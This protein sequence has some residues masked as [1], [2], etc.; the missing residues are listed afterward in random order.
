MT[1]SHLRGGKSVPNIRIPISA[2]SMVNK[3]AKNYC[4][5]LLKYRPRSEQELCE[6]LRRKKFEEAVIQ[7]TV[8]F[9]KAKGFINDSLFAKSWIESR[10]RKPLGFR[11]IAQELRLKGIDESL[12]ESLINKAGSDYSEFDVVR[13]VCQN[14]F[15]RLIGG[16]NLPTYEVGRLKRRLY[17]YLLR[18]GFSPEVVAEAINEF[19]A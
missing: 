2:F 6:R 1:I 16:R 17:G 15:P 12:I 5:L 4:L 14:R 8:S 3:K 10:L 7:E 11:R 18:R 13:K 9:L 19:D